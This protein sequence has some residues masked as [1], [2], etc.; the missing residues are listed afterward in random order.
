MAPFELVFMEEHGQR[1][2]FEA[3]FF[4]GLLYMMSQADVSFV[5]PLTALTFVF[6]TVAAKFYLHEHISGLRWGGVILIVCGAALITYSEKAKEKTS[7]PA[8]TEKPRI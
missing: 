2:F 1:I 5:W 3:L 8:S 4:V 7:L 6:A